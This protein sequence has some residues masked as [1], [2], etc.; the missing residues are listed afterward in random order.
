MV[1]A[2]KLSFE[3]LRNVDVVD[4]EVFELFGD[5][6]VQIADRYAELLAARIVIK[7]DGR[8]VLDRTLKIVAGDIISENALGDLIVW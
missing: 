4:F 6:L 1:V 8:S 7:R 5:P 3:S 2:L